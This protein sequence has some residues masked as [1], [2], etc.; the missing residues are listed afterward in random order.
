MKTIKT[1]THLLLVDETAEIKEGDY[2]LFDKKEV[3]FKSNGEEYHGK[4]LCHIS[5]NR[6]YA[7]NNSIKIIAASPKLGDLP[8][9]ETL[10]P[11]TEDD[12]DVDKIKVI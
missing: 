7:V 4:D 2:F 11:N 9:F 1:D 10:P 3:R 12:V 5:G 8:E 6:R